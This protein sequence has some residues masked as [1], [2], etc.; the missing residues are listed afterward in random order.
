[1]YTEQ[2]IIKKI[3]SNHRKEIFSYALTMLIMPSMF[4][5]TFCAIP[6]AMKQLAVAIVLLAIG[7]I[8]SFIVDY[9]I[10]W[11]RFIA[12]AINDSV[13][14]NDPVFRVF[15]DVKQ[16]TK[17]INEIAKDKAAYEH[18]GFRFNYRYIVDLDNPSTIMRLED[19]TNSYVTGD[20]HNTDGKML[21][22]EDCFNR[23]S[24]FSLSSDKE[25]AMHVCRLIY[26]QSPRLKDKKLKDD[27]VV[28]EL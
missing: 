19:I 12:P 11:K 18:D 28:T 20:A 22:V 17:V 13:V 26:E 5:L 7:V 15:K 6:G 8:A 10:I 9:F 2:D 4:L 27:S 23:T 25:A 14:M 3:R 16:L 24:H 21:V 1:M